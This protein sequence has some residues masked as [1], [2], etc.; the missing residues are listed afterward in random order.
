VKVGWPTLCG[1]KVL[2]SSSLCQS[3]LANF[4]NPI[5]VAIK[6]DL[7]AGTEGGS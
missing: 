1:P 5:M 6:F 3:R 4:E 7:L 2:P